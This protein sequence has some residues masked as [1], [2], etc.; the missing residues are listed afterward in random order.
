MTATQHT[1][2]QPNVGQAFIDLIEGT[3]PR[4]TL[5]RFAGRYVVVCCFGSSSIEPGRAALGAVHRHKQAFDGVKRTFIGV[6]VDPGEKVEKPNGGMHYYLDKDGALSRHCGAAPREDVPLGTQYRVTWTIV[7]PTMHVVGH[8]HTGADAAECEKVFDF[9]AGLPDNDKFDQCE[10]PAPILVLPNLFDREFCDR[11]IGLYEKANHDSGFMR[12]NVEIFDHSFKR[13]RDHF[14]ED[15]DI[16]NIILKRISVCV[17]PEIRKL[18][19]MKITRMERYLVACYDAEE[20]AHFNPHRDNG[21]IITAHRRYAL[22]VALNEDYAGGDL[23]FPEYNRRHHRV[24]RGWAVV[25]PCAILHAVTP[26]T[27]GRRFV[28]LPFLFDEAAARMQ[29]RNRATMAENAKGEVKV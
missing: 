15:E 18:F 13:R 14:I 4:M 22:S 16:K 26:V 8:F 23:M 9:L 20:D 7:D 24:P 2:R 29:E 6:A 1:Y 5:D 25:F 10:I 3:H 19:F 17:I 27:K 12:N 11:L 28:F 21:Q